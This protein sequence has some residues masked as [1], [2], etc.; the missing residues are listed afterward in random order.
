M[1]MTCNIC[2]V[3]YIVHVL[4]LIQKYFMAISYSALIGTTCSEFAGGSALHI[5]AANLS[6]RA[7]KTLVRRVAY[8]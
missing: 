8:W 4:A 3:Q 2:E 7:A 6:L 1:V 5:A